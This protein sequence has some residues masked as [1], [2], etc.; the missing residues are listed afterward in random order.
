M[1]TQVNFINFLAKIYKTPLNK[2]N[3]K[4][5]KHQPDFIKNKR[6]SSKAEL[7]RL[8]GKIL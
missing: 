1:K 3:I 8:G 6:I 7:R 5:Y 4:S 2:K